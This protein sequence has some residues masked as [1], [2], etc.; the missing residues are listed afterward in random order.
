M[1]MMFKVVSISDKTGTAI[2]R[3]CKVV[4]PFH[5]NIDY[6]VL[7]VHPKRPDPSQ[8][9]RVEQECRTAD[10]ID[11][12]YFRTAEMLRGRYEWLKDIPSV[13]THNNPYSIKESDWNTYEAVIGNNKSITKDLQDITASRV[14]HIPIVVDPFFWQFNEDYKFS[15]SVIMVAN[16]I[17][18]KK[19]ILPVALACKE[20]GIKMQLVGA[21]SQPEYFKEIIDTGVVHFAQECTDEE[22][23]Q[24]Y[25][26]AGVHVCN[27]IDGFESGT[28]PILESIYCGVPVITRK[29]GHVADFADDSIVINDKDPDDVEHLTELIRATLHDPVAEK[30]ASNFK[31]VESKL[32]DMRQRAW[33]SIKHMNPERRAFMYQKLYR[34]LLPETPVT[35]IVPV[36][37][38]PEVTRE[39]LM[40]ITN[41]T[42]SNIEIIVVDDGEDQEQNI[43]DFAATVSIPV[44]YIRLGGKG[45]NLAKARNM[46]AIEATSDILVFCDQ[47]MIMESDC[48]EKFLE[49]LKPNSWLY[50]NKGFKKDFVENLS[51]I[52][53]DD[54]VKFGMF[55]ERM[56]MYGGL[57]QETRSRARKQGIGIEWVED[58]KATPKGKSSNKRL[59]KYQIMQMK[60]KLWKVGLN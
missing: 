34:E 39:N 36:A 56:N 43:K 23:R 8:L 3:L 19:G 26:E 58:A 22:L 13:L 48:I 16:R 42:H 25:Y 35:V 24:M 18:S 28:M 40:A 41:Q 57:S 38:K 15:K 6:V 14:E 11:Y 60:N 59:Q 30:K 21:I 52:Y 55:N 33:Y 5:K 10:V 12:Q 47:R 20:L 1:K 31:T 9:A 32:N 46:A 44:R 2:D 29:I 51:C 27:S 49:V 17:E 45:Y 53:R 7:D 37:G 54:F 50:G 4:A